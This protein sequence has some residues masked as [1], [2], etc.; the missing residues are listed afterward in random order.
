MR[1]AIRKAILLF[2]LAGFLAGCSHASR[3]KDGASAADTSQCGAFCDHL[4]RCL[5]SE[6]SDEAKGQLC[7]IAR[8][9]SGCRGRVTSAAGYQGAFQFDR[10]TWR[11]ECGPIFERRGLPH[12]LK[13]DARNDPCCAGI[14]TAEIIASGGLHRWP[15]CGK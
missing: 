2:V 6:F 7:E 1:M 14:C 10:T 12:C 8:C 9:E 4:N 13:L 3:K 11:G 5:G 15:T